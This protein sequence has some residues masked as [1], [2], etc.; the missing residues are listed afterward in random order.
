MAKRQFRVKRYKHPRLKFV[1]RSK[2]TGKW[3]RRFFQTKAEAETYAQQK[4]IELLN[5]GAEAMAFPTD[6]RIMAQ[7]AA[8][9]LAQ[10][11]KTIADAAAFYLKYLEAT[12]RSVKVSQALTVLPGSP[13]SARAFRERF[14][15]P[16]CFNY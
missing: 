11:K 5:Q 2:I 15:R 16:N 14:W 1:V 13:I 8:K 6:L 4:E 7:Q 3:E 10:Y 9:Q 12:E